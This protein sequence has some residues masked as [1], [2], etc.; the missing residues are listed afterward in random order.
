MS[1]METKNIKDVFNGLTQSNTGK[2]TRPNGKLEK[3]R[4]GKPVFVPHKLPVKVRYD[5]ETVMLLAN[6]ER[7]V[8]ELK[9]IGAVLENPHI[10]IRAYLKKEAVLSSKIEGTLASLKDLNRQEAVG[11]IKKNDAENLRLQEV[12]NYVCALEES[13]NTLQTSE[14]HVDLELL[15]KAHK[16]L[17]EGVRGHDKNPGNF[18]SQQ[19]WIIKTHRSVQEIVYTPPPPKKIPTL[20]ENLEEFIQ[21]DHK[22]LSVLVQCAIIHYQ[23]EAIHPFLDGNGRIGRL[24]LPLMLHKKDVLPEPLLYLSAYFDLHREQYY[25]GLLAVSQKSRWNDW[26]KFFLKAFTEQAGETIDSIQKLRMLMTKYKKT[27]HEKN[28]SSNSIFLM[29]HLFANP[30]VTIPHAAE[31]LNITYPSAKNAVMALVESGILKQTP[32]RYKSKVFVAQEIEKTL[33]V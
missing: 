11:S 24:M 4:Y 31:F 1:L 33:N 12:I 6:A 14:Q 17:M 5:R 30:Y 26:I 18:R 7:K 21:A 8:G 25:S 9:G 19:N 15:K 28:S 22:E 27:L 20:L 16:K 13:L 2:F 32:I 3:D 10:L 23:F 29:E